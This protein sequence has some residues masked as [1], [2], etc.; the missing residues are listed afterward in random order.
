[1]RFW[2]LAW[3][4]LGSHGTDKVHIKQCV[5]NVLI[6]QCHLSRSRNIPWT[7]VRYRPVTPGVAGSNPVHSATDSQGVAPKGGNLLSFLVFQ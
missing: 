2:E 3:D 4:I 6:I 5:V 7:R 1:M